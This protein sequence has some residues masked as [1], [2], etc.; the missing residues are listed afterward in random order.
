MLFLQSQGLVCQ[1]PS[2][3]F[4]VKLTGNS[5]KSLLSL[6]CYKL[7][8][9]KLS[10]CQC[11]LLLTEPTS[12]MTFDT[13]NH[14]DCKS[15]QFSRAPAATEPTS[16][17]TFDKYNQVD[18]KS[19]QFSYAPAATEPKILRSFAKGFIRKIERGKHHPKF[20]SLVI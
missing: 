3:S 12:F 16:F 10:S 19:P 20:L 4:T 1:L 18:C 7:Y 8:I 5:P 9:Y 11:I 17:M 2:K 15:P 14:E 6:N 13:Y